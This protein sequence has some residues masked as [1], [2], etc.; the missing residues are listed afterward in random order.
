MIPDGVYTSVYGAE[1]IRTPDL[2]DANEA[3]SQ[4][5]HSPRYIDDNDLSFTW[6]TERILPL[7]LSLV[8]YS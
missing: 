3:L 7:N 2:L 4:L 5:S 6:S 8:K 1:G